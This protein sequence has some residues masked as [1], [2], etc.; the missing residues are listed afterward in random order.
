MLTD[1]LSRVFQRVRQQTEAICK[2][3]FTEDYVVQAMEDVSP[4]KWHLAH[5][6][7]FFETF[8]LAAMV[9]SYKIFDP[10]FNYRFNS[11]Y[12]SVGKPFLRSQRG[13]LSRPPTE[14][15][16]SYRH[17]VDAQILSLLDNL[18]EESVEKIRDLVVLGLHHEQQHQE[19]ILMDVKYN[20]SHDPDFPIYHLPNSFNERESNV[21]QT[22]P[23]LAVKGGLVEI[24]YAGEGFCFDN[25]LPQHK[26]F[27]R[28]YLISPLLV[29]NEEYMEF[30]EDKGYDEPN[31]W[32]ADG[33]DWLKTLENKA[34]LY[35][36]KIDGNWYIF[37]LNGLQKLN[38]A[39]PVCHV[40]Y[41]EAD[42]YARWKGYRLP[43]ESEWENFVRVAELS[44]Q[45]GNFLETGHYHPRVRGELNPESPQFFGDLWEWTSSS[46]SPYPGYTPLPGD[47]GEYNGKFMSN[48]FVLRGGCCITPRAHI[49]PS[50]RNFFQPEKR[51]QFSGIRLASNF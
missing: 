50:Y 23:T 45:E 5:T 36:Y 16:Y 19:L 20:F 10:S 1:D 32:L 51:W 25:E 8:V 33:W 26:A 14:V 31:W 4:P 37:T 3:L 49:R 46:Y 2:P 12:Q 21:V 40:N 6:T 24:G 30:I 9:K 35:W 22:K 48:Q 15:I 17:Y 42:A 39:E 41:Y 44:A 38:P 7:W 43:T 28:P 29:S 47:V 18:A 11:Y 27:L 13:F 34:P